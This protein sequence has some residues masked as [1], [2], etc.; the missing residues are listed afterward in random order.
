MKI[1]ILASII[2]VLF[3][4]GCVAPQPLR[5]PCHI[6]IRSSGVDGDTFQARSFYCSEAEQK[7]L[8]AYTYGPIKKRW[9]EVNAITKKQSEEKLDL[10]NAEQCAEWKKMNERANELIAINKKEMRQ[11]EVEE[12]NANTLDDLQ[13]QGISAGYLYR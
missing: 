13:R 3:L 2:G 10:L 6:V 11:I 12:R 1:K 8:L 5:V 7:A 9:D 4:S